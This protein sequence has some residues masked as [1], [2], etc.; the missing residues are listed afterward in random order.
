[1]GRLIPQTS[2]TTSKHF[3]FNPPSDAPAFGLPPIPIR[4]KKRRPVPVT[5]L[6]I[7]PYTSTEWSKAMA[8]VK[9]LYDKRQYKQCSA[10]CKQLLH[11]IKDSYEIHPLYSI[12]IAFYAASSLELTARSLHNNASTKLSLFKEAHN[13]YE[14]AE[15]YIQDATLTAD[16]H[17]SKHNSTSSSIRSSTSSIFSQQS[18]S[19]TSSTASSILDSSTHPPSTTHHHHPQSRHTKKKVSFS[20]LEP[21]SISE[22]DTDDDDKRSLLDSFPSPPSHDC[23]SYPTTSPQATT[24]TTTITTAEEQSNQLALE[25]KARERTLALTRYQTHLFAL[26]TQLTYHTTSIHAQ[27]QTLSLAHPARCSTL[28]DSSS[29]SS[30]SSEAGVLAEERENKRADL[31]ERIRRGR[32]TGWARKRFEGG[33]YRELCERA[34][35]EVEGGVF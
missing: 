9:E 18:L 11:N 21:E 2:D 10:G 23:T 13:F 14:K 4:S 26:S 32:E 5:D 8:E 20:F 6:T 31:E 1:M 16:P 30:S 12:Y 19:S 24:I 25:A 34:L 15:S 35:R 27:M 17:T 28:P 7:D 3:S 29:S 22:S 33:R